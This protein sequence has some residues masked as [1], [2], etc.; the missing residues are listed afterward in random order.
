MALL[1]LL[2]I[3]Q[4]IARRKKKNPGTNVHLHNR[5]LFPLPIGI[6]QFLTDNVVLEVDSVN[7]S[8]VAGSF[9]VAEY[10]C[11]HE[12]GKVAAGGATWVILQQGK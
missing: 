8:T 4:I 6:D 5:S 9:S 3:T 2:P 11:L 1:L 7:S 10:P 12:G